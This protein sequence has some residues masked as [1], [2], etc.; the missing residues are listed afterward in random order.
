MANAANNSFNAL[1]KRADLIFTGGLFMTVLLLIMP[2][3][4]V[5]LDLFLSAAISDLADGML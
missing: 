1:M 5:M 3:P 2:V 4:P